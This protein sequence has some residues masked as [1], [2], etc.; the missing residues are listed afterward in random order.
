WLL[1]WSLFSLWSFSFSWPLWSS[2][3][4][5]AFFTLL[6]SHTTNDTETKQLVQRKMQGHS[7]FR[8]KNSVLCRFPRGN[9]VFHRG[10]TVFDR[11]SE[12]KSAFSL[13]EPPDF[14][15]RLRRS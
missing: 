8:G 3:N 14:R 13:W 9:W 10:K 2:K 12:G 7:L 4:G 1:F 6:S 11:F 15:T 5:L